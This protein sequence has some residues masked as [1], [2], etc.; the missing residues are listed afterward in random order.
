[1][2]VSRFLMDRILQEEGDKPVQACDVKHE[3]MLQENIHDEQT[4]INILKQETNSASLS[5]EQVKDDTSISEGKVD[6]INIEGCFNLVQE[7]SHDLKKNTEIAILNDDESPKS[8]LY[9]TS[10]TIT[11]GKD[12][13]DEVSN[14]LGK[15]STIIVSGNCMEQALEEEGSPESKL[16][17]DE[18]KTSHAMI[19]IAAHEKITG[20]EIEK[21]NES[22]KR[23]TGILTVIKAFEEDSF[24]IVGGMESQEVPQDVAEI[25]KDSYA[26]FQEKTLSI[27]EPVQNANSEFQDEETVLNLQGDQQTGKSSLSSHVEDKALGEALDNQSGG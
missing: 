3:D 11:V 7:R 25:H 15:E 14:M 22:L 19:P 17:V 27:F 16:D 26:T 23:N 5:A 10:L 21:D 1:M 20:S 2:P 9:E 12:V 4:D 18:L 8:N 13:I 6:V 24:E